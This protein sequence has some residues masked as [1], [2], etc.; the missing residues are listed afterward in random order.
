MSLL[1]VYAAL[2][3]SAAQATVIPDWPDWV[4]STRTLK[5]YIGSNGTF[6]PAV[7]AAIAAWNGAN[8]GWNLVETRNIGESQIIIQESP[9]L[10][11]GKEGLSHPE[12]NVDKELV[13]VI[14]LVKEGLPVDKRDAAIMHELG[15]CMRLD[16]TKEAT[17]VMH[18]KNLGLA[19]P[20]AN[21]KA[22]AAAS[23]ASRPRCGFAPSGNAIRNRVTT[24]DL[25]PKPGCG[26]DLG[27][28]IDVQVV[29]LTG[30]DFSA[31][32]LGWTESAITV[33]FDLSA[34]ADHNEVFQ[35]TLV[36]SDHSEQYTGVLT[37]TDDPAPAGLPHA[38]AGNDI[39][40]PA[41]NYVTLDGRGSYHD[42][43]EV[44]F[45]GTWQIT[46][47]GDQNG[48][49]LFDEYGTVLLPPGTYTATLEAQDYYGRVSQDTLTVLVLAAGTPTLSQWGLI[50]LTLL[51]L[52]AGTIIVG[53]P[54]RRPVAA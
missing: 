13:L 32:V 54:R 5:V 41:G 29:S 22:E 42:V 8:G 49:G 14:A 7:R 47:E 52:T 19:V 20:S 27:D 50:V 48:Y 18:W 51:L 25:T 53:R 21:D 35:A 30:P 44:F 3:C 37:I 10:P 6:G 4:D 26:I 36:Y 45:S 34:S 31:Y 16:D 9:N 43:P 12:W 40:V 28:L 23:D 17:D 2:L 24:L 15:H 38:V 46:A 39:T 33:Q 1:L 11:P